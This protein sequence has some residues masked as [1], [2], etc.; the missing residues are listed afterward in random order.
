MKIISSRVEGQERTIR[1]LQQQLEDERAASAAERAEWAAEKVDPG[2]RA[3]MQDGD[4]CQS[5][6]Q[7]QLTQGTDEDTTARPDAE[8]VAI[9]VHKSLPAAIPKPTRLVTTAVDSQDFVDFG[10]RTEAL[11]VR[12]A[13]WTS[14]SEHQGPGS[15]KYQSRLND[16]VPNGDD[17]VPPV[18]AGT[19]H[20][21]M[22]VVHV[23]AQEALWEALYEH[24][25]QV[26]LELYPEGPETVRF[27]NQELLDT[28]YKYTNLTNTNECCRC[29]HSC[30][31][32]GQTYLR[33]AVCHPHA[34]GTWII[35][36]ELRQAQ[37]LAVSVLDERRAYKIRQLR[38]ELVA[39][40]KRTD[41][42]MATL[43]GLAHL[44][45]EGW[46]VPC[47]CISNTSFPKSSAATTSQSEEAPT[48]RLRVPQRPSGLLRTTGQAD[49]TQNSS[50]GRLAR[51]P[52]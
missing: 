4:A 17:V 26:V 45:E 34:R 36:R 6:T 18:P 47:Q 38:D 10:P 21:I 37:K 8:E 19:Q 27:G 29:V 14:C 1:K 33:N 7:E 16:N 5:S 12:C 42:T 3:D 15:L 49:A 40:A 35:D 2:Q 41:E 24:W 31:K 52:S 22:K 43:V 51:P 28:I 39:E 44:N 32:Y 13:W 23:L 30:I 48:A 46:E 25:P 9:P 20:R 11:C 50:L